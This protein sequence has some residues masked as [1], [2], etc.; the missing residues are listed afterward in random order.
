[1]SHF[2]GHYLRPSVS[3]DLYSL[4]GTDFYVVIN[5]LAASMRLFHI[6]VLT[7]LQ[8]TGYP[9]CLSLSTLYPFPEGEAQSHTQFHEVISVCFSMRPSFASTYSCFSRN[10]L[11]LT[12]ARGILTSKHCIQV[13]IQL[14]IYFLK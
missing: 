4:R 3:S 7:G 11:K 8:L 5:G 14:C 12:I 13:W 6:H 10:P 9:F 1:M 2:M